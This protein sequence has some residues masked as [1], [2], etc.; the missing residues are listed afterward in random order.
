MLD[1]LSPGG[2]G[3]FRRAVFDAEADAAVESR[4]ER[5]SLGSI[6]LFDGIFLHRPELRAFWDFS[7]FLRVEWVRNHHL[8]KRPDQGPVR[9]DEPRN[10]RYFEGQNTYFRECQ[11]W[12]RADVVIDNDDVACKSPTDI[13]LLTITPRS[14]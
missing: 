11:P 5:A 9:P 12:D 3:R 7:V 8:R 4:E 2:T 13:S 10:Y 14:A 6:L 1:P